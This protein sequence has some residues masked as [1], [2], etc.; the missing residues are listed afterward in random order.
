MVVAPENF[1]FTKGQ[2]LVKTYES[3][4]APRNF[5]SNCGSSLYD[6]LGAVYFVAAGLM[7]DLDMQPELPSAG[8]LQGQLAPDRRRR[9]AVRRD[10][11]WGAQDGRPRRELRRRAGNVASPPSRRLQ[12]GQ[13]TRISFLLTNSSAP[14]LPSSRPEPERLTPPNGSSAPSAPTMLT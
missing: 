1:Q 9:T 13:P 11:D 2:D 12:S 8:R 3:H 10:A 4:L 6:D 5:C 14:Y 7:G